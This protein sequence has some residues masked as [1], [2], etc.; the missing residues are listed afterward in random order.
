MVSG[1][2]FVLFL[3]GGV[4]LVDPVFKKRRGNHDLVLAVGEFVAT[5]ARQD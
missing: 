1:V 3:F 5:L 4:G 2:V